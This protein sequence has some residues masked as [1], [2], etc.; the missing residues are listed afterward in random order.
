MN[1]DAVF[2]KNVNLKKLKKD[3]I[4]DTNINKEGKINKDLKLI[5][6][7]EF[8]EIQLSEI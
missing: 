6:K 4:D 8:S 7:T 2:P 1:I 3:A 5:P